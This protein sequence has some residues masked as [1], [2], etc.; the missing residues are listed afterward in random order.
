MLVALGSDLCLAGAGAWE[1]SAFMRGLWF[2][3]AILP[4]SWRA[5]RKRAFAQS[6]TLMPQ[7]A[8]RL[9][10]AIFRP[11]GFQESL[12][13]IRRGAPFQQG[14]LATKSQ[15]VPEQPPILKKCKA[16]PETSFLGRT[17]FCLSLREGAAAQP[18]A[19]K[20][21]WP[22]PGAHFASAPFR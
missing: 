17:D 5:K 16:R 12:G 22:Q 2:R 7:A 21:F 13:F 20:R 9:H 14:S 19:R 1:A 6:P 10:R 11:A 18:S 8:Q 3:L 4:R 15:A